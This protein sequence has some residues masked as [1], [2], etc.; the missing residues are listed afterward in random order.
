MIFGTKA[1]KIRVTNGLSILNQTPQDQDQDRKQAITSNKRLDTPSKDY[2]N[3]Q[4][5]QPRKL[6]TTSTATT[7]SS[8]PASTIKKPPQQQEN[9]NKNLRGTKVTEHYPKHFP[10][11]CS[12]PL[13][14]QYIRIKVEPRC[15]ISL[16]F[17]S[18]VNFGLD[19]P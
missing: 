2:Q 18:T 6:P 5:E 11:S 8:M 4:K 13:N 15:T 10:F 3:Q 7:E 1:L 9:Q 19:C 12:N 14:T 16:Y 17:K